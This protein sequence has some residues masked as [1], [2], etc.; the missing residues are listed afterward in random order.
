MERTKYKLKYGPQSNQL[1]IEFE[2]ISTKQNFVNSFF[3][4]IE[5]IDGNIME[6]EDENQDEFVSY[7]LE[8]EI[9]EFKISSDNFGMMQI[10]PIENNEEVI[11]ELDLLFKSDQYFQSVEN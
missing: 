8:S 3:T 1:L 11:Y 5:Y 10:F 7:Y 9:G 4:L 6:I 2:D